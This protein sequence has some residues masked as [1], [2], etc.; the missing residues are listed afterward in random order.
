MPCVTDTIAGLTWILTVQGKAHLL[1]LARLGALEAEVQAAK[2]GLA[3]PRN[4]PTL[5][6]RQGQDS[7][8]AGSIRP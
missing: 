2:R 1:P 6:I 8:G 5:A 7:R 4:H 3:I